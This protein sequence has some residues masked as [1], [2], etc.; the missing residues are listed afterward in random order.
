MKRKKVAEKKK[1]KDRNGI[2]DLQKKIK[3]ETNGGE[4]RKIKIKMR[5]LEEK[6]EENEKRFKS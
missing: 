1:M 2:G 5:L 6:S 3:N 4:K